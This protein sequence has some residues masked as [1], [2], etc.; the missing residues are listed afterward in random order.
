MSINIK[1]SH[2]QF[3]ELYGNNEH[4]REF[5]RQAQL[6]IL[7]AIEEAQRHDEDDTTDWTA[8]FIEASEYTHWDDVPEDERDR[9]K[10]IGNGMGGDSFLV[11]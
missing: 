7:D 6:A 2:A 1:I 11:M 10:R 5:G 8:F 3:I 4:V 9:V